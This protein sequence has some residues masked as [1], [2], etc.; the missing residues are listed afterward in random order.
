MTRQ[1]RSRDLSD[2]HH[3]HVQ[4]RRRDIATSLADT[5]IQKVASSHRMPDDARRTF[6]T[7]VVA[8]TILT[9]PV[10]C[11]PSASDPTPGVSSFGTAPQGLDLGAQRGGMTSTASTTEEGGMT[12]RDWS[13]QRNPPAPDQPAQSGSKA[14]EGN[15]S[16]AL[17]IPNSIASDLGS[18]N[19]RARYDALHYWETQG[20]RAPLDPV[21]EVTEDEDPAVRAKA[22]A[23]IEQYWAAEQERE[24]S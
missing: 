17:N 7:L 10:A 18:P 22:M 13:S 3:D 23:I 2:Y 24:R 12:G 15:S 11:G 20:T 4:P 14:D 5:S 1:P 8:C 19:P 21:F 6:F 16:P 9:G